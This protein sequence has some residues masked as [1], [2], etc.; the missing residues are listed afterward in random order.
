MISKNEIEAKA[1][2]FEMHEGNVE[3]DYVFGWLIQRKK[4]NS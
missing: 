2:E 3:R 1:K 4:S